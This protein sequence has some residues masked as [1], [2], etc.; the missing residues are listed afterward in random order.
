MSP[1]TPPLDRAAI[2]AYE[3]HDRLFRV[4]ASL[5]RLVDLI[6][7]EYRRG[8]ALEHSGWPIWIRRDRAD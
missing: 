4:P 8:G 5:T 1:V 7:S 2:L 6:E 3:T